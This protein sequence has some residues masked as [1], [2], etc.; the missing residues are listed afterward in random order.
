MNAPPERRASGVAPLP[1]FGRARPLIALIHLAPLP[2]SPRGQ[3]SLE[4]VF[5]AALRDAS[6][7]ASAGFDGL[8]LE[9][10]GDAPFFPEAVPPETVAA[11]SVLL[12][13]L[14]GEI[15]HLVWGVNVLRNDAH[16][17]L[18]VAAA[19]GASFIRVNVHTGATATDQGILTGRAHETLRRRA[20][21]AP[22]VSVFA[23]ALVKHGRAL[24]QDSLAGAV[25]DLA[26]RG[27]ADAVLVTG[28]RTGDAPSLEELAEAKA[29]AGPVPVL[30]ASGATARNVSSFLR[31]CDGVIVG[32]AL[33]RGGI[34]TAPVDPRR[35]RAFVEQARAADPGRRKA[36]P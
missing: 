1:G 7:L 12:S 13:R 32:T 19:G 30:V 6:S 27:L 14:R 10:F 23:D 4:A 33:K 35:A 16:A 28:A 5:R 21:L 2:G 31:L 8:L 34:T 26:Q 22:Q 29:A 11:M 20:H 24:D 3:G 9:N 17:A 36:R 25:R 18:A 15:P